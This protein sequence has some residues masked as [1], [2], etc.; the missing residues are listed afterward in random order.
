MTLPDGTS[1]RLGHPKA[2]QTA[3]IHIHHNWFFRELLQSG[4]I[5]LGESYMKGLWDSPDISAV[6][7]FFIEQAPALKSQK[8]GM[9]LFK[10]GHAILHTLN[11]NSRKKA[12]ENIAEHYDLGNDFY[13][14]FLDASM[15][16]SAAYFTAP[17]D[18]LETAQQQKYARLA[19]LLNPKQD[20]HI[21][22]IGS[23]WGSMALFLARTYHCK[24]TTLTLSTAQYNYVTQR[25]QQE[26]LA[27]RVSVQLCDYRDMKGTFDHV[28]SIEM[29]EAV[30]ARYLP[31]YFKTLNSLLK[32]GGRIALQ[33]I[34]YPDASY[35]HY[36]RSS[37]FIR[38]H[39][40]PGGHLPSLGHITHCL[41]KETQLQIT[42]RF[43]IASSYA[44]TL[45][46]WHD[47]FINQ[48]T[49][50]KEMGF[51][52]VFFRKWCYYFKLCEAAFN[53]DYLATY[54]LQLQ[55]KQ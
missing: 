55:K 45:S 15:T 4:E 21:L 23:G 27:D 28:V 32:P 16:Y 30:G 39:I 48:E 7:S 43:N 52:T 3:Q 5:G 37:D 31:I 8:Y 42:D 33:A 18:S 35:A 11:R 24:V 47:R 14:L 22:E 46:Q 13:R 17:S 2:H 25:L 40:F 12:K 41:N 51:N 54:Q 49:A 26:G 44:R 9:R 29:I 1:V 34:I 36:T 38:K 53:T 10:W 50:I 6:V 20:Q 19:E